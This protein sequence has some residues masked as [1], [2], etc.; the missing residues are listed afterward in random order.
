VDKEDKK[1]EEE[2]EQEDKKTKKSFFFTLELLGR[3]SDSLSAAAV[4]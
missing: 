4:A 2:D 3:L 1:E